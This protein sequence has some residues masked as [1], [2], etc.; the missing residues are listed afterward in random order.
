MKVRRELDR[1][2]RRGVEEVRRMDW[3]GLLRR[4]RRRL[5]GLG[6]RRGHGRGRQY[7][8]AVSVPYLMVADRLGVVVEIGAVGS[9]KLAVGEFALDL[10]IP[11]RSNCSGSGAFG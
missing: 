9:V 11:L 3:Y 1:E 8:I 10:R 5:G 6:R 7:L 2:T 4:N